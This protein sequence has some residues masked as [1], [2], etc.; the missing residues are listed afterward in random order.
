MVPDLEFP[1]TKIAEISISNL[2]NFK[3][4]KIQTTHF[5]TCSKYDR[6]AHHQMEYNFMMV[7]S[8][9]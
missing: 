1:K 5:E 3:A 8:K 9:M 6:L 7:F 4:L 2:S